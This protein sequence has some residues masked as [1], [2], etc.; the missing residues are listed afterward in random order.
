LIS[1]NLREWNFGTLDQRLSAQLWHD[2]AW[3]RAVPEAIGAEPALFLLGAALLCVRGQLLALL[4]ALV[5][6]YVGVFLLFPNLH[7]VHNYYQYAN[8]VFLVAAAAVT[9][10]AVSTK[11]RLACFALLVFVILAQVGQFTG[12]Y[13]GCMRAEFTPHNHATLAISEALR[14]RTKPD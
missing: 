11:S 3:K 2:L 12:F 6:A 10:Y 7:M 13:H 14:M 8:A 5:T 4:L 9:L 1:T